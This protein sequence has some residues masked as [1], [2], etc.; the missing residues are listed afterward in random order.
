MKTNHKGSFRAFPLQWRHRNSQKNKNT[1]ILGY[2]FFNHK[3]SLTS[4][5]HDDKSIVTVKLCYLPV[6]E[7]LW[8]CEET[9]ACVSVSWL[10][11]GRS[12]LDR[13]RDWSP[14]PRSETSGRP[15]DVE[16]MSWE[17]DMPL[18]PPELGNSILLP[19]AAS[20]LSF[21]SEVQFRDKHSEK[22]VLRH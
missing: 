4:M 5:E 12:Q 1:S 9:V 19:T 14:R 8:A 11:Q 10:L 7:L 13:L 17:R 22:Q 2:A 16:D 20:S 3:P 21:P 18:P 15:L 6:G